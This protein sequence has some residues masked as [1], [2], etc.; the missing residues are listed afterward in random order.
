MKVVDCSAYI[1]QI[2]ELLRSNSNQL[3]VVIPKALIK[4]L[5]VLVTKS[6]SNIYNTQK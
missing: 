2:K 4:Y 1:V 6:F 3:L 5:G